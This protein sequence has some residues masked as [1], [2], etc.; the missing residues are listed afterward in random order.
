MPCTRQRKP[1]LGL[2]PYN[3][4]PR[5][6]TAKTKDEWSQGRLSGAKNSCDE[7]PHEIASKALKDPGL[8]V[9]PELCLVFDTSLAGTAFLGA[10]T[11]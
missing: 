4:Q 10:R 9:A 5:A 6:L 8:G 11:L 1:K 7:I 2:K 3:H